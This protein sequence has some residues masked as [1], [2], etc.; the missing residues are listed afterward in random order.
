MSQASLR[1][2]CQPAAEAGREAGDKCFLQALR[3]SRLGFLASQT[4]RAYD[5]VL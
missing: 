2:S 1:V 3:R 4:L 5:S